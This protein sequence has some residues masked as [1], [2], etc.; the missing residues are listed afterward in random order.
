MGDS[1][2]IT[3]TLL[4]CL[5]LKNT[6]G[7]WLGIPLMGE[8]ETLHFARSLDVRAWMIEWVGR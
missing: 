2:Q 4:R 6:L 7:E 1:S 3:Q 8:P 5:M